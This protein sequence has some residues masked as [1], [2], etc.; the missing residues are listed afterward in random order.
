MSKIAR[1][2]DIV[3][4]AI[5]TTFP[6]LFVIS[7]FYSVFSLIGCSLFGG[8]IGSN[9]REMYR[10]ATNSELNTNYE[11][12]NFNDF[13]NGLA[14]CWTLTVGNQV[15]ILVNM[16]T[17]VRMNSQGEQKEVERDNRGWFF[18]FFYILNN[19]I[20]FNIFIGQIIGISTF[21]FYFRNLL[22]IQSNCF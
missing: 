20:L 2:M 7:I 10:K 8:D 5:R 22:R 14:F 19:S 3:I 16:A 6:F 11:K 21:Y 13:M 15:P 12:L 18:I 9:T 4:Y 1:V 17:L